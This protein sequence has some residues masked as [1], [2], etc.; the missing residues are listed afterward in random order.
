[1]FVSAQEI[2]GSAV[3]G[4]SQ[5][6]SK[7]KNKLKL[8]PEG[9]G[10]INVYSVHTFIVVCVIQGCSSCGVAHRPPPYRLIQYGKLYFSG[11]EIWVNSKTLQISRK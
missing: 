6:S 3:V 11:P 5:T 9:F 2:G 10:V 1:M 4:R 7:M 8:R